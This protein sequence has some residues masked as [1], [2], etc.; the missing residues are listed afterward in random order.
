MKCSNKISKTQRTAFSYCK[1]FTLS[2]VLFCECQLGTYEVNVDIKSDQ[3]IC[4]NKI[5][6]NLDGQTDEGC[7]CQ[8][9]NAIEPIDSQSKFRGPPTKCAL[10]Y[11]I[12]I[13]D[14][15]SQNYIWK[16]VSSPNT[17]A[18]EIPCN[19]I[20]EDCNGIVDDVNGEDKINTPCENKQKGYCLQQG[21]FQCTSPG[22]EPTCQTP[23][24]T[25]SQSGSFSIPYLDKNRTPGWDWD[26][27]GNTT[28]AYVP[29]TSI[30]SS[31]T[32]SAMP[33]PIANPIDPS[34]I[35][36]VP[37]SL[38]T[39]NK[40]SWCGNSTTPTDK[41]NVIRT[42]G[43]ANPQDTDCGKQFLAIKC[44]GTTTSCGTGRFE[45]LTV[46]CQ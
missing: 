32:T 18:T 3:E 41:Y 36:M 45:Y 13:Q 4:G 9:L 10:G 22:V 39:N 5:D 1:P 46:V 26:C 33:F 42:D 29:S 44:T 15:M 27:N 19:G 34:V 7:E 23:I 25:T 2:L 37:D 28:A 16:K 12:C 17:P 40:G 11:R 8:S 20:D 38:C 43:L 6:D 31:G 24:S 21:F 14:S 30:N 35:T